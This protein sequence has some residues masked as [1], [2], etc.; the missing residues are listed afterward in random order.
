MYDSSIPGRTQ[1]KFA[2]TILC[3][4]VFL[5]ILMELHSSVTW[6]FLCLFNINSMT[7]SFFAHAKFYIDDFH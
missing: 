3:N 1:L 7:V 5:I 4:A 2:N 6:A